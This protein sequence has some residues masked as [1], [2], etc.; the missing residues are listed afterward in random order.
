[1]SALLWPLF[2]HTLVAGMSCEGDDLA[3]VRTVGAGY[4]SH[5]DGGHDR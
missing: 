2:S 4:S 5:Y 1:V 3:S